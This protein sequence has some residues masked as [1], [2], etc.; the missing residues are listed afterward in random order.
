MASS[1]PVSAPGQNASWLHVMNRTPCMLELVPGH[2]E[3][4]SNPVPKP[5][6]K[7][8]SPFQSGLPGMFGGHCRTEEKTQNA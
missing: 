4:A 7:S 2:S 3:D 8:A 5:L 1:L 6:A